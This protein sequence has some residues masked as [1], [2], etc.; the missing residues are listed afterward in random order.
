[1]KT[2]KILTYLM[3]LI[4][5]FGTLA[6]STW[7][8]NML[9]IW[10]G[11]TYRPIP[12]FIGTSLIFVFIGILIG[13]EHFVIQYR[14]QGKWSVNIARLIILGIPSAIFAFY[15]PLAFTFVIPIPS[16]IYNGNLFSTVSALILGY[17]IVTSFYKNQ[18]IFT[19][20]SENNTRL[21]I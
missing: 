19:T 10:V 18:S 20:K 14:S 16:F 13:L 3:Y 15:I 1:M 7:A 6:V 4:V 9:K 17:S 8:T 21:E 11:R 5:L 12:G 2:S